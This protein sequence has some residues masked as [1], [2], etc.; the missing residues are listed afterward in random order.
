MELPKNGNT[1]LTWTRASDKLTFMYLFS[2][3][4]V[5]F[6][7]KKVTRQN[8]AARHRFVAARAFFVSSSCVLSSV[9][10]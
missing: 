4:T 8:G 7:P 1:D 9:G 2:P 3:P 10:A 6:Q 5:S